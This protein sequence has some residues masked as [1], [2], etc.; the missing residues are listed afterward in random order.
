MSAAETS[1]LRLVARGLGATLV[2]LAAI[3]AY[4]TLSPSWRAVAVHLLCAAIVVTAGVRVARAVRRAIEASPP[5]ALDAPTPAPA[6]SEL[7]ERFLRLRDEVVFSVRSRRYFDTVLWPR[8]QRLAGMDLAAPPEH[9]GRRRH[10][11]PRDTLAR[12]LAE[13]EQRA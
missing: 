9:R 1:G 10:G 13:I 4:L 3:P 7:D 8:L 11:P 5:F 6:P 2:L 12:L